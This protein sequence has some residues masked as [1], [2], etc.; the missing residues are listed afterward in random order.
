MGAIG[1]RRLMSDRSAEFT[2]LYIARPEL[3]EGRATCRAGFD[4][5][6]T[7]VST[8]TGLRRL[9]SVDSPHQG[10]ERWLR[11]ARNESGGHTW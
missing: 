3:V 10:R 4:R 9:I 7:S 11:Y 1:D 5:L 8:P 2:G 6:T